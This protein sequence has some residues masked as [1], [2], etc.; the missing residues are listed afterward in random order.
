MRDQHVNQQ[1]AE[2][3]SYKEERGEIINEWNRCKSSD[4]LLK[5]FTYF[6]KLDLKQLSSAKDRTGTMDRKKTFEN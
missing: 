5:V 3:D 4:I 1:G 6:T 2:S